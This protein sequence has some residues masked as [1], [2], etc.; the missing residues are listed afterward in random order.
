MSSGPGNPIKV[1]THPRP[2]RAAQIA[3]PRRPF[4]RFWSQI[5]NKKPG[6]QLDIARIELVTSGNHYLK[7][8]L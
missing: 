8:S 4:E 1:T 7:I 6:L 5:S 3:P 2:A